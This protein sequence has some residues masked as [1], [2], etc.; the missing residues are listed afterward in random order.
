MEVDL[1]DKILFANQSMS[2]LTGYSVDELEGNIA[3]DLLANSKTK[4]IVDQENLKRNTGVSS[5]YEVQIQHKKGKP[6]WAMISGAPVYDEDRKMKGSIGVHID[7]TERKYAEDELK[8]AR[9]QLEKQNRELQNK[10]QYLN[11]I[12]EFVTKLLKDES[13]DDIAGDC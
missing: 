2:N 4:K 10:Q 11:A 8:N 5:V 9:Y 13:L 6:K 3:S 7:I 12:N 1:N